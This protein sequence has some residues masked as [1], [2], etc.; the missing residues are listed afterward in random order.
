M[1]RSQLQSA[2]CLRALAPDA[3]LRRAAAEAAEGFEPWAQGP[4]LGSWWR[5][6]TYAYDMLQDLKAGARGWLD[7]NLLLQSDGGENWAGNRCDAPLLLTPERDAFLKQPTFFALSHFALFLPPGS[8]RLRPVRVPAGVDAVAY[9][10]PRQ[11]VAIV[12]LNKDSSEHCLRLRDA[13]RGA[14]AEF[15]MPPRS[16]HTVVWPSFE[17]HT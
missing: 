3:C 5:L 17:P 9:L 8:R 16:L 14:G 11:H 10:T 1:R 6:E 7:W 13:R 4:Q 15:C 12:L 2:P